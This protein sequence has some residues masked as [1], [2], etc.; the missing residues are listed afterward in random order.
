MTVPFN[1]IPSNLRVPLFYAEND[2][3]MANQASGIQ[4][5]LLIGQMLA[6]GTAT[7]NTL[8]FVGTVANAK[9]LFG[10]GSILAR[11]VEL[12]RGVDPFGEIWCIG[13]ADAGGGAQATGSIALTGPATAN[14]TMNL[15]IGGQ[16]IPVGVLSADTATVI[17]A[18][19]ATAVNA[20]LDLPVTANNASGTVTFTARHKG[21]LGNDIQIQLNYG[22][23]AANESLPAGVTA[24]ITAMSGGA[25]DP[26]LTSAIAAMGDEVF[27]SI[28]H[29]WPDSTSLDAIKSLMNDSSGRWSYL[30]QIFGH[31]WTAKRGT[32]SAL[33]SAGQARN[34]PHHTIAGFEAGVPNPNWEY[35]AAYA[36]KCTAFLRID[37]ARP[38]QTGELV[39]ILPAPKGT[40]F[41][42][43][44]RQSLLMAGIATSVYEGGAMRVERAVTTYQKN[45]NGQPD[46]SYLDS[47]TLYTTAYVLTRL[48]IAITSKYPRSSLANDGTR[49]GSGAAIVTPNVARGEILTQYALMETD[50]I[51]E[52]FEVF[53]KYLIVERNANNPN[54]MD[55][56]FP[57]DYVN[58]LRVFALLNQFRLQYSA[59]A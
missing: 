45:A 37:P 14:G 34:D 5:T 25:T 10:Q 43:P 54:R 8:Q 38:T 26:T 56:L 39:G 42:I 2:N 1:Y 31:A 20:N 21:T 23:L 28:V 59:Q 4:A 7:A 48:R 50:G 15:Y 18:A 41:T 35:I 30:K 33:I 49:F 17:G 57:P 40:R 11:M 51:V 36:A 46:D 52:N 47:E 6:A 13:V 16:K 9:T 27:D 32:S 24:P 19:I 12:Y 22:G 44:E 53:K 55:V 3:S 58:Q 29:P